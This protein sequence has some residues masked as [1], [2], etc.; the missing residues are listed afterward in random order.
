[1]KKITKHMFSASGHYIG[2]KEVPRWFTWFNAKTITIAILSII[3]GLGIIFGM[4]SLPHSHNYKVNVTNA[5]P[6]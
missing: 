6:F 4:N 3:L 2:S 5:L 1:M